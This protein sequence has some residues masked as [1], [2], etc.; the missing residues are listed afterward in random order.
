MA[1]SIVP[2]SSS[3]NSRQRVVCVTL[4]VA[5]TISV[6]TTATLANVPMPTTQTTLMP[7][8]ANTWQSH[9]PVVPTI[10]TSILP[11]SHST[12]QP[13]GPGL[14]N[15]TAAPTAGAVHHGQS[16][17][18]VINSLFHG[19]TSG[20]NKLTGTS[21][22]GDSNLNLGSAKQ[23]FVAGGLANF[24]DLTIQVGSVK[25]VVTLG[26]KL[27]SAEV[28]A[29][30][31]VLTDG[32]QTIKLSNSGTAT[33]GTVTL[34]NSLLTALDGSVGGSIGSLTISHGVQVVDNLSL[35]SISGQLT[36][37]GSILT[38]SGT[39]GSVDTIS[40]GTIL[41]GKGGAIGSYSGGAGSTTG[42]LL[43][44]DPTLTAATSLTNNGTLSS[45]GNLN[46]NA[47][48]IY[49][50]A[51]HGTGGSITAA[52][53]VNL[54]TKDLNNSGSLTALTG[55]VNIAGTS[56]LTVTNAGGTIQAKNG[57]INFTNDN[58]DLTVLGGNLL[59]QQVN[60][61]AGGASVNL[62]A[63]NVSGVINASGNS[64]HLYSG[65]NL[66]LGNI[67]ASGD[68]TITAVGNIIVSGTS[69]TTNGNNLA[70][71][72]GGNII[73]D[74]TGGIDTR[75][76]SS[77]GG[78]LILVAGAQFTGDGVSTPV[79]IMDSGNGGKGTTAGGLID[80]TGGNGGTGAVTLITTAGTGAAGNAGTIQMIAY[81]GTGSNTGTISLPSGVTVDASSAGG[82]ANSV[83]M[84][85]GATSGT[86][87][88]IGSIKG[89]A[90]TLQT[91][92]PTAGTG[93]T[94]DKTGTQT[95]GVF[96]T[97]G[98]A[99]GSDI[100]TSA[101]NATGSVN[102]TSGGTQTITGAVTG[103]SLTATTSG[104]G[105][106]LTTGSGSIN[107]TSAAL[108]TAS[109]SVIVSTDISTGTLAASSSSGGSITVNQGT[110]TLNLGALSTTGSGTISVTGLGQVNVINTI[111]TQNGAVTISGTGV[112]IGAVINSGSG[113]LSLIGGV[114][115]V[116]LSGPIATSGLT[117][118]NISIT[119]GNNLGNSTTP[120]WTNASNSLTIETTTFTNDYINDLNS[121]TL[122][123]DAQSTSNFSTLQFN[124]VALTLDV[125]GVNYKT[126]TINNTNLSM[127]SSILLNSND[128]S[129]GVI[130]NGSG[131][132]T[133]STVGNID[134][135]IKGFGGY[136]SGTNVTLSSSGGNIGS[137][138][139]VDVSAQGPVIISAT[140]GSVTA[141]S[142]F[143]EGAGG[144][145]GNL[146][147]GLGQNVTITANNAINVGTI[148][149]SGGG[150]AGDV[151]GVLTQ[152]GPGGI[153]GL[154]T[155]TSNAGG[156][157]F[158][159]IN[160]SGGG[161][162][163]GAG[164]TIALP[165]TPGGN[166]GKAGSVILSAVDPTN[167][168]IK[169]TGLGILAYAGG[170]GGAGGGIAGVVG[171]GGGGGGSY[172]GA[173]GGG[174]GGSGNTAGD[175]GA[176]GGGGGSASTTNFGG[177]GGAGLPNGTTGSGGNGGGFAGPGAGGTGSG[178]AVSGASGL[179]G[180][181]G[182]G[183]GTNPPPGGAGGN[184]SGSGGGGGGS[185]SNN[186]GFT[187]GAAQIVSGEGL[188][189]LTAGNSIGSSISPLVMA[190]G[191]LTINKNITPLI[192][193]SAFILNSGGVTLQVTNSGAA[194]G[195]NGTLNIATTG[196][197]DGSIDLKG[198]VSGGFI[199]ISTVGSGPNNITF[200]NTI[201]GGALTLTT[202]GPGSIMTNGSGVIATASASLNTSGGNIAIDDKNAILPL[203]I[204]PCTTTGS[205]TI[206]ITSP[207]Q[208][209]VQGTIETT[210]TPVT[211]TGFGINVAASINRTSPGLVSLI[212]T[213]TGAA[214]TE[215]GAAASTGLQ[216][217]NLSLTSNSTIGSSVTPFLTN[218]S[219]TLLVTTTGGANVFLS[220]LST[221]T[222]TFNAP[223]TDIN[224][225]LVL[226]SAASILN[227][228]TANYG[229]VS[230][231]GTGS[232]TSDMIFNSGNV[233]TPQVG[234]ANTKVFTVTSTGNID[235]FI[236]GATISLT[237]TGA[238]IGST[239]AFVATSPSL[240]L[241]A[242]MGQV[243]V[244]DPVAATITGGSAKSTFS[245]TDQATTGPGITIAAL[246]SINAG[247]IDLTTSL[248][249]SITVNGVLGS[250]T[251]T[252]VSL[253]AGATS[254][255]GITIANNGSVLGET[256]DLTTDTSSSITIDGA[257]GGT[258]TTMVSVNS[259]ATSGT[260]ITVGSTGLVL[261]LTIDLSTSS[262]ISIMAN[263]VVGGSTTTLVSVSSGA[264]DGGT[265]IFLAGS[266]IA[267]A[268]DLTT[269]A[270][271]SI[272]VNGALGGATTTTVSVDSGA[273]SDSTGI[274]V[275]GSIIAT[276]IDLTTTSNSSILVNG[277]LGSA[278][279][280]TTVSLVSAATSGTGITIAGAIDSANIFLQTTNSS[281][282]NLAVSLGNSS[283]NS[284]D[285]ESGGALTQT[286]ALTA[287]NVTLKTTGMLTINSTS[288][289]ISATNSLTLD[290]GA[291]VTVSTMLTTPNIVLSASTG[292]AVTL[293][294]AQGSKTTPLSSIEIDSGLSILPTLALTATSIILRTPDS[295][296]IN[297]AG[298]LNAT[299]L[300]LDT[301]AGSNTST[302]AITINK[303]IGVASGTTTITSGSTI[304]ALKGI[305][306]TGQIVNL[307]AAGLIGSSAT[308]PL[309]LKAG[310]LT[311][312]TTGLNG[313]LQQ[314]GNLTLGASTVANQLT[315]MATGNTEVT[316][317]VTVGTISLSSSGSTTVD[318]SGSINANGTITAKTIINN[319]AISSGPSGTQ[320]LTLSAGGTGP[321]ITNAGSIT[322][323]DITLKTTGTSGATTNNSAATISA[324]QVTVAGN[325]LTNNGT[326]TTPSLLFAPTGNATFTFNSSAIYPPNM[327]LVSIVDK[328]GT[329]TL[330]GSGTIPTAE[331]INITALKGLIL[332]T[333]TI[334]TSNDGNN[335]GAITITATTLT[336]KT[337]SLSLDASAPVNTGKGGTVTLNLS[338]TTAL[339]IGTGTGPGVGTVAMIDVANGAGT[340]GG[341]VTITNGA[342][343]TAN[344]NV[345]NVGGNYAAGNGANVSIVATK[346]NLLLSNVSNIDPAGIN[347]LTLAS[348]SSTA[349]KLGGA[350]IK[351]NGIRDGSDSLSANNLTIKNTLGAISVGTFT[352][353]LT[354]AS[355]L[356][357]QSSGAMG[358]VG[359]GAISV[360]APT[361]TLLTGKT[362]AA[363]IN[364][365]GATIIGN[366]TAVGGLLQL[367]VSAG[368][369]TSDAGSTVSAGSLNL[370]ASGD[371]TLNKIGTLAITANSTSGSVFIADTQTAL[372]TLNAIGATSS[373]STISI[374]SG[375]A[376]KTTSTGIIAD[377]NVTLTGG[378]ITGS[379]TEGANITS[380]T[381]GAVTLTAG[382]KGIITDAAKGTYLASGSTVSLNTSG[383][384][385]GST[386]TPF[387]TGA[388]TLNIIT[389]T[390]GAVVVNDIDNGSGLILGT[391]TIG[392][393]LLTATNAVST[394]TSSLT[395]NTITAGTAAI[396]VSTN[397]EMLLVGTGSQINTTNG[398]IT[399]QNTYLANGSNLP[400]ISIGDTTTIHG[401]SLTTNKAAGNVFIAIGTVPTSSTIKAGITPTGGIPAPV[402][403]GTV[404][405]GTTKSLS[406]SIVTGNTDTLT[407]TLR[408]LSFTTGIGGVDS[409]I[410][411]GNTVTIIADPPVQSG[412]SAFA[413]LAPL[414]H[415]N[416]PATLS[417]AVSSLA[418]SPATINPATANFFQPS[419]SNGAAILAGLNN[420]ATLSNSNAGSTSNNAN[421]ATSNN[422]V[423]S[424]ERPGTTLLNG[425]GSSASR[426]KSRALAGAV[427]NAIHQNL[428]SGALMLAPDHNTVVN[429]P[430]GA[431]SIAAGSVALLVSFEKGLA[432]YDLHDSHKGA[433]VISTEN[434]ST[435]LMPGGSAVLT[436]AAVKA[437]EDINPAQFV[438]YRRLGSS[439]LEGDTK[440]YQAEF[441][442]MSMVQGLKPLHN[443]ATSTSPV[444][445]KTIANT[446]KTAAI[447]MDV[448]QGREPFR[449]YIAPEVTACAVSTQQ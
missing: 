236:Q 199:N 130:G 54:S 396:T 75:S 110:N 411:L 437:F 34:N 161:G 353:L 40:A 254:G 212:N 370:T 179:L 219:N 321:A 301:S 84:I 19:N 247:T 198:A 159:S 188:V 146:N 286:G 120:F 242:A 220:D 443:M 267:T 414:A 218:V 178:A 327:T 60:L 29:A 196:V 334:L 26:T 277:T 174:L 296:T 82:S 433:V 33:G 449:P 6:S 331:T 20:S 37:Y 55:N 8:T 292:S 421:A 226:T 388:G 234:N 41:N 249:S 355:S 206:T 361:L 147:G 252:S 400:Q 5:S 275:S 345:I 263:G 344:S 44:A 207:T 100:S 21:S 329:V 65:S 389:G 163:G 62:S 239:G 142:I 214:L 354:G 77:D 96:G 358:A 132:V 175:F 61:K 238:S 293:T 13:G 180:S 403:S 129:S 240:S 391:A 374:S 25:E 131:I 395:I 397:E 251:T 444:N 272:I 102:I 42:S 244:T 191:A 74:G 158:G 426:A 326:L 78:S 420:N 428:D 105:S 349:F 310:I 70:L 372:I 39:A 135:N 318:A 307:S 128:T 165:A 18:Q 187:G 265:G 10:P 154:V 299:N 184:N 156:I 429:T 68:P 221:G 88:T 348:G 418:E 271:S 330:N 66:N 365:N 297:T 133:I 125:V 36:N 87:I 259:G 51:S 289:A 57:N 237:S 231:T 190:A 266:I 407:G 195:I 324:T 109:G 176:G 208:I 295:I 291:G 366:T 103:T 398:N 49:N 357:L 79:V 118:Q 164:S 281:S 316:K 181:G 392:S 356:L 340:D 415:A 359:S 409:Q 225:K 387:R 215:T 282:I 342:N 339:N 438:G 182:S 114:N 274:T 90:V 377:G 255:A 1:N 112:D 269:S 106:I 115:G 228:V 73:S 276:T 99:N 46:I 375:G 2:V 24:K 323:T 64:V 416:G 97:S 204:G 346:G 136:V 404:F 72:A 9:T 169:S 186:S 183:G 63:D 53:N 253:N 94:I 67:D 309:Q 319:G 305:I 369:L 413:A 446:I 172:G 27:T 124:S 441:D 101:I 217:E 338:G 30:Q 379:I 85:A 16:V 230:V 193:A 315:I 333:N 223:T 166:G 422:A 22:I 382:T 52:Q 393:L 304:S 284:I 383:T 260:G 328:T 360:S 352:G 312:D 189:D 14:T 209:N 203:N 351:T 424:T 367:N 380:N 151:G 283:T 261:G 35:L 425:A 138:N 119:S 177:G 152:G 98:T 32:T 3:Y 303:S 28:V 45:A 59:S 313:W 448:T 320:S 104:T 440:V 108:T 233:L 332:P 116:T 213:S 83:T 140:T 224:A 210:N 150:G 427:S 216:T 368:S 185:S 399:L 384:T 322:G 43:A 362:G 12:W 378:S 194:V 288:P 285:V 308:L 248:N 235:G 86:A 11:S 71:V 401:D 93:V 435:T 173:G 157:T 298:I 262:D 91:F 350:L 141:G 122:T 153:G 417:A 410:T 137:I 81:A 405:F 394:N 256:I 171:G 126:V 202:T 58:A 442:I 107:T 364:A 50:V 243:L 148:D 347:S 200:E 376:I 258:T 113:L 302:S 111:T 436:S 197:G 412:T 4:G 300:T 76:A 268:I 390:K 23:N 162:G 325:L 69:E 402:I 278:T 386:A 287:A 92:T 341:S 15:A 257:L 56:A 80:L 336:L 406:G 371:I 47:P 95:L 160:V 439:A 89:T 143:A 232:A 144:I 222:L 149:A 408:N 192:G 273:T 211:I 373:G 314:T 270:N 343:V 170:A 431:V 155:L 31:Q 7:M 363:Y 229:T 317:A 385:I 290:G 264:T 447:L 38:A 432:V 294:V 123:F 201:S 419:T 337:G 134:S 17:H 241:N 311:L 145:F 279:T 205:G 117:G 280:T 139:A 245:F 48:V 127:S 445:R 246:A 430:Y 434:N 227:V 306:I 335:G 423:N 381:G 250:A 168:T 121:G 167:G